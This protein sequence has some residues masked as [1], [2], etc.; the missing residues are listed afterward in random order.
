VP[1]KAARGLKASATPG[2]L[3]LVV[4]APRPGDRGILTRL[5]GGTS[6]RSEY[7]CDPAHPGSL[8]AL[9]AALGQERVAVLDT[10]PGLGRLLA[11][12]CTAGKQTAFR[13]QENGCC[14]LS[15][16]GSRAPRAAG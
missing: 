7:S 12:D 6:G 15:L 4:A 13:A 14:L 5:A 2:A 16:E 11:R 10:Q 3:V 1:D 8:L 9:L